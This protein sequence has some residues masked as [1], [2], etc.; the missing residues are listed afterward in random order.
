[1]IPALSWRKRR[2]ALQHRSIQMPQDPCQHV[3]HKF[4]S[5]YLTKKS[6]GVH[7]AMQS[8]REYSPHGSITIG[9]DLSSYPV[10]GVAKFHSHLC[11]AFPGHVENNSKCCID[12]GI[13][14]Q[15]PRR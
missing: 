13:R 5:G 1:M 12:Q 10:E 2:H 8:A 3:M 11:K 7:E 4:L 14:L 6:F 9:L 15:D